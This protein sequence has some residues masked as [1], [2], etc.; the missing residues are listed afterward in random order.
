M[1]WTGQACRSLLAC[2]SGNAKEIFL[3]FWHN[4][5]RGTAA[6]ESSV[7][8]DQAVNKGKQAGRL[9]HTLLDAH[10]YAHRDLPGDSAASCQDTT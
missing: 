6:W 10:L 2:G 9:D 5:P 4:C 1:D 8:Y 7:C 3:D